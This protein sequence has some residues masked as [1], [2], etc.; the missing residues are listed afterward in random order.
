MRSI[1]L[2]VMALALA[3]AV[4][5]GPYEINLKF[6]D[7]DKWTSL[8]AD[9]GEAW[10]ATV[11]LS[12]VYVGQVKKGK[13][14]F[15]DNESLSTNY[16]NFNVTTIEGDTKEMSAEGS[17]VGM[18]QFVDIYPATDKCEFELSF[19][20]TKDVRDRISYGLVKV[21]NLVP[22]GGEVKNMG[23]LVSEKD[24]KGPGYVN[25]MDQTDIGWTVSYDKD[26]GVVSVKGTS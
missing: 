1:I 21:E 3:T 5:A 7:D 10:N 18:F 2:V 11:N 6:G 22:V 13:V 15:V 23:S 17:L 8:N 16:E 4:F 25:Y 26:S 20:V 19:E 12:D 14:R 9:F 24:A